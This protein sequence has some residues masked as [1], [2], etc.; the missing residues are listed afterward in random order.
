MIYVA[1]DSMVYVEL[2]EEALAQA[3]LNLFYIDASTTF[4]GQ[5]KIGQCLLSSYNASQ[6]STTSPFF[7]NGVAG[8]TGSLQIDQ[9][10]F[11]EQPVYSDP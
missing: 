4:G 6:G 1:G 2:I 7:L 5:L 10:V 3:N 11:N 8:R 9:A